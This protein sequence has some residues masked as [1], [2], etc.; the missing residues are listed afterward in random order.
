MVQDDEGKFHLFAAEMM[1][2]CSL[3]V[4][5]SLSTVIHSVGTSAMGPFDR[6]GVAVPH[7]AHNPVVS[8]TADK[9]LWL[10]WTCGCPQ[11]RPPPHSGCKKETLACPGGAEPAWTTTV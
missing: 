1:N 7:E 9:S 5:G 8:R 6:V 3:G 11:A 4:W 2:D 10:I